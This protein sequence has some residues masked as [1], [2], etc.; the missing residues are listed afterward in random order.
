ML[1][2]E[3]A[4]RMKGYGKNSLNL[5]HLQKQRSREQS[6]RGRP[7]ERARQGPTSAV[8]YETGIPTYLLPNGSSLIKG[9]R[10]KK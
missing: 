7:E 6:W 10:A 3:S 4:M 2:I 1:C 5:V 9:A 8:I